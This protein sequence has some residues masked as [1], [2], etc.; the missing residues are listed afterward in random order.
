[1]RRHILCLK[2]AATVVT[3]VLPSWANATMIVRFGVWIDNSDAMHYSGEISPGSPN[4]GFT[5]GLITSADQRYL[6]RTL[7]AGGWLVESPSFTSFN[8]FVASLQQSWRIILDQG[9]ATEH[10]Y[11]MN[12][13]LGSLSTMDLTPPSINF[14]AFGST[15]STFQPTFSFVIPSQYFTLGELE[16]LRPQPSDLAES[17]L[18]PGATTWS[19]G[20]DLENG[21]E[22][23]LVLFDQDLISG[24]SFS[25]P[26]D[27]SGN[28]LADW[29]SG[30]NLYM[31]G[32][33][34]FF[35]VPEVPSLG[36]W[37]QGTT[38]LILAWTAAKRLGPMTP[39]KIAMRRR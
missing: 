22:Y 26:V 1:M 6:A 18:P 7:D 36:L 19:P 20:V 31:D 12:L 25:V 10:D 16:R 37:V 14:P 34:D 27:S 17:G 39:R 9:L 28:Q 5:T 3:L 33:S 32:V 15:I 4:S 35:V 11:T 24:M 21:S 13:N 29:A 38:L 2:S 23:A 30:G 8:D